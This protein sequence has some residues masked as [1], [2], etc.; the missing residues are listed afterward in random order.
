MN[1]I[2]PESS[3]R[4]DFASSHA[5]GEDAFASVS[6]ARSLHLRNY[7]PNRA[8][9]S[10]EKRA[11]TEDARLLRACKKT[12][13]KN[14][15]H[16]LRPSPETDEPTFPL[17]FDEEFHIIGPNAERFGQYI[18]QI[19]RRF[20]DFPLHLNWCAHHERS[21][22]NFFL[23]AQKDYELLPQD[24]YCSLNLPVIY[25]GINTKMQ[26]RMEAKRNKVNRESKKRGR[27]TYT[28][29]S[30]SMVRA[31]QR[32]SSNRRIGW[33]LKCLEGVSGYPRDISG[34]NK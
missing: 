12:R 13:G 20:T 34:S 33:L 31:K 27:A 30:K 29:G 28:S 3:Y 1:H 6:A 8:A 32:V 2:T 23:Q 21:F 24:P 19:R 22:G 15:A 5:V 9:K 26:E 16:R 7:R 11:T 25:R 10:T 17:H 18:G 14:K 4:V